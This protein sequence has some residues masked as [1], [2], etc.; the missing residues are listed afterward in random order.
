LFCWNEGFD[1]ASP[2]KRSCRG[3]QSVPFGIQWNIF[4]YFLLFCDSYFLFG[5]Q[6]FVKKRDGF[7]CFLV[8]FILIKRE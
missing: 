1:F 4:R 8:G 7:V 3:V 6:L 5:N 2:D